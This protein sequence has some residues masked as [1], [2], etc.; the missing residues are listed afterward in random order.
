M[1]SKYLMR[2]LFWKL[3]VATE[4]VAIKSTIGRLRDCLRNAAGIQRIA[5]VKY[6]DYAE[7]PVVPNHNE[8]LLL[9]RRVLDYEKEVRLLTQT[10]KP[11]ELF[12]TIPAGLFV[13][14]LLDD[15]IEAIYL[16]PRASEKFVA[17]VT[18]LLASNGVAKPV[19]RSEIER[20]PPT[21]AQLLAQNFSASGKDSA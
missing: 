9:K 1:W 12:R 18:S 14:V 6:I 17:H 11:D 7:A 15:L 3:Y 16:S 2:P 19:N 21:S 13:P 20:D 8:L 4:G 10:D 5:A